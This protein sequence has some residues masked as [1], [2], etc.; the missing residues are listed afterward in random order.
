M[1]PFLGMGLVAGRKPG[2]GVRL[3]PAIFGSTLKAWWSMRSGVLDAGNATPDNLENVATWQDLSGNGNHLEQ[4]TAGY[5][6]SYRTTAGPTGG[7]CIRFELEQLKRTALA[8]TI[9]N[10]TIWFIAKKTHT[11]SAYMYSGDGTPTFYLQNTSAGLSQAG[12]SA[13]TS[14]NFTFT[15]TTWGLQRLEALQGAGETQW[16]DAQAKATTVFGVSTLDGF[17]LGSRIDYVLQANFDVVE[18]V[19]TEGAATD[20]QQRLMRL[21]AAAEYGFSWSNEDRYL[22]NFT[23]ADTGSSAL[24]LSDT[25]HAYELQAASTRIL[26]NGLTIVSPWTTSYAYPQINFAPRVIRWSY[27]TRSMGGAVNPVAAVLV[28]KNRQSLLDML[29]FPWGLR[30]LRVEKF[31][32][33]DGVPTV[34]GSEFVYGAD[35]LAGDWE[36]IIDYAAGI[37]T[38]TDP[39]D[40]TREFD[41]DAVFGAGDLMLYKK[42]SLCFELGVQSLATPNYMIS[43]DQTSALR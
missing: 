17:S 2:G 27:T 11:V 19:I 20:D 42:A 22:D 6:P 28:T 8:A 31:K 29:H 35:C 15:E 16:N 33:A 43:Y 38:V 36:M 18:L 1:T 12:I 34:V 13:G 39:Y 32:P 41:W 23:A 4:S 21:Y 14:G 5:R 7:P 25:G 40:E 9:V 37:I 3:P 26:S 10:P 24:P 30:G